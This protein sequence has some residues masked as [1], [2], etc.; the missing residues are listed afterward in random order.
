MT[1]KQDRQQFIGERIRTARQEAGLSQR[2]LAEKIGFETETAVSLIESGKR[3]IAI[4]EMEKIAKTL[5]RDINYFLGDDG[6]QVSV[7]HALR[8]EKNLPPAVKET[9]FHIL[10]L[11]KKKHNGN[12]KS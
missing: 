6:Y 5:Q 3:R 4:V 1:N 10:E 8:A 12:R 11:A 7:A 9:I 2:E